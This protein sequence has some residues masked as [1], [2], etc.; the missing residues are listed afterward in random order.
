MFR[1]YLRSSEEVQYRELRSQE[2]SRGQEPSAGLGFYELKQIY[3]LRFL[4]NI[5]DGDNNDWDTVVREKRKGDGTGELI[6][7]A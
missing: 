2:E 3:Q 7:L 6:W 1:D 5:W 4:R